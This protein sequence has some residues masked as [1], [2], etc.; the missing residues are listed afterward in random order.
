MKNVWILL[1]MLGSG[2][3]S[4]AQGF[5]PQKMDSLF[6]LIEEHDKGMGSISLF[7]DGKEVYHHAFGFADVENNISATE[8]TK[9]RIGSISKTFTATLIMQL[10]EEEKLSLDTKLDDFFPEIPNADKIS[11]EHLLRH[12]SGLYNFTDKADYRNWMDQT[13]SEAEMV[14]LFIANGTEFE[15]DEKFAYSNTNYVLLSYIAEKAEAKPFAAILKD[16]ITDPLQLKHTYFGGK[17]DSKNE[18][19]LSYYKIENWELATET[20]MS[21]PMGAGGIVSTPADLNTFLTA[22]FSDKVLSEQSL[23]QMT[24]LIDGYGLG[25]IQLPFYEKKAYGHNGRI[26]EFY[27]MSGY[28]PEDKLAISYF[29]NGIGMGVNDIMIA[30]LSIYFGREYTLPEFKPALTLSPEALDQYLGTYSSPNFPLKVTMTKEDNIL[31]GQASGQPSFH[32]EAIE[33]N[34]FQFQPAGLVLEFVPEE[35]LMVLKQA[36]TEHQLKRE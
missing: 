29:A 13:K 15:P 2:F 24:S 19:A 12:R 22:L 16:R 27:A 10:V 4:C 28:F 30:A 18:E 5:D 33:E 1:L 34:V 9:F 31:V 21:I 23:K 36:G 26:D 7:Q 32:L 35:E 3:I 6:S 11:I 20:D 17:I 14:D 8:N 25:I